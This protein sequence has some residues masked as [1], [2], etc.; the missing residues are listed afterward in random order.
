MKI[1]PLTAGQNRSRQFMHFCCGQNKE[2]VRRRLLQC[3]KQRIEG[4]NGKHVYLINDIN[5]VFSVSRREVGFLPQ[6]TDI[7]HTIVA[8]GINFHHI[9]NTAVLNATANGTFPARIAIHR[10]KTVNGF[11]QNFGTGRFTR[12]SGAGK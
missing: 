5:P 8:G 7:I 9:H 4:A 12:S 3:F 6:H 11:G 1:E 10:R 2:N